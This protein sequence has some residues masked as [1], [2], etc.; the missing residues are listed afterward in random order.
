MSSRRTFAE[1]LETAPYDKQAAGW[2]EAG[3]CILANYDDDSIVVYQ[4][5]NRAIGEWAV[6]HGRLGGPAFSFNRMSWIKPNFLWMMYRSGWGTKENQEMTL[7]LRIKQEF[8]ERILEAAVPS[9]FDAELYADRASWK[10]DVERSEVRLQWD[11]DHAPSGAKL[12]RWA[13]QIGL[14]DRALSDFA[15]GLIEVIDFTAFVTE[16][17][18]NLNGALMT[19]LERVYTPRSALARRRIGLGA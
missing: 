7:A 2:P 12:E 4:A 19:P 9:S 16:Q 10:S 15:K 11:P 6:E 3:R 14:R 18:E 1:V 8:F 13:V 17:A 5:Y